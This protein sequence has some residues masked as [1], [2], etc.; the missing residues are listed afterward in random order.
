MTI[1]FKRKRPGENLETCHVNLEI[2]LEEMQLQA[3]EYQ[4]LPACTGVYEK[5]MEPILPHSPQ[6]H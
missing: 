3:E 6:A 1:V 2:G 4:G 5:G